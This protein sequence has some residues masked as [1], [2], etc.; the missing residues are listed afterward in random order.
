MKLLTE[1]FDFF[2][3]RL[4]ASCGDKLDEK[5]AVVCG[6]CENKIR[7]AQEERII[8]EFDRKFKS[9]K[10]IS[11][12]ASLYVFEKDKELQNI[13]HSLKYGKNFRAGI[14][15]GNKLG[16][17]LGDT[18]SDIDLIVPVPLH[19]LK[20]AERGYNQSYYIARGISK[21][22]NIKIEE[23]I[24]KR[25]R[26]TQS[27]TKMNLEERRLNIEN[28]F[29]VRK[30]SRILGRNI[31]IVDDVITTGATVNECGK[32]LKKAGANEVYAASVAIA[33]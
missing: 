4:C 29:K 3:P 18:F 27:Q 2:M 8:S 24:L 5:T 7:P 25:I 14:Y 1:I 30:I 33:D 26:F 23:N 10:Y 19:H 28:A 13:I 16:E 17:H 20:K 21:S 31:L 6:A 12:F 9:G 32:V 15:L 11:G 22:T